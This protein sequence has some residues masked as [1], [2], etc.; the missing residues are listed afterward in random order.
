MTTQAHELMSH[1]AKTIAAD[2]PTDEA[3][4]FAKMHEIHHLPLTQEGK[5]VGLVCTCDLRSLELTAPV[6]EGLQ[7]EPV[8]VA[9]TA[10][11]AHIAE[12][13]KKECVSSVLV[14]HED[15]FGI[16]TKDDLLEAN[17]DDQ[18]TLDLIEACR[19]MYCAGR[20][21]LRRHQQSDFI[22]IQCLER[23]AHPEK[24]DS[25]EVD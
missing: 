17:L 5:V 14:E 9:A 8:V 3:L 23:A 12:T 21:H 2:L 7:R 11:T 22:C 10:S 20:M 4:V 24:F 16:V 13:M 18:K 25:G 15:G 6:K 1:P 19:C